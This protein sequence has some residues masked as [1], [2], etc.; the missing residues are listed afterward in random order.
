MV[1]KKVAKV[2]VESPRSSAR[3]VNLNGRMS[4]R[5]L[6]NSIYVFCKRHPPLAYSTINTN[7]P[8]RTKP[9]NQTRKTKNSS[10]LNKHLAPITEEQS[11][12]LVTRPR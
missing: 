5:K 10:K 1:T 3:R 11:L 4:T 9:M 6:S 8:K 7:Q 2:I 12:K